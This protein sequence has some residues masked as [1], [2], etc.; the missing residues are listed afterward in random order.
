VPARHRLPLPVELLPK[1][2]GLTR[3]QAPAAR[4][5]LRLRRGVQRWFCLVRLS[6]QIDPAAQPH[7]GSRSLPCGSQRV[8][9][10]AAGPT[11]ASLPSPAHMA[12]NMAACTAAILRDGYCGVEL[13]D[14]S[15]VPLLFSKARARPGED[16]DRPGGRASGPAP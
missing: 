7:D 15:R 4:G 14:L 8:L 11:M 3:Y 1:A 5:V 16:G 2:L 9:A 6:Y 13:C 10:A 12:A